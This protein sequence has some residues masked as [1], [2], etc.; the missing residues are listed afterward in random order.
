[1]VAVMYAG[2]VVEEGSVAEVFGRASHPY[3]QGLLD[4]VPIPGKLAPGAHLGYIP[5]QV[6]SLLG[7]LKGCA[8]RGRCSHA[9]PACEQTIPMAQGTQAGHRYRCLLA[10]AGHA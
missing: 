5:G 10:E 8:F 6:P 2:E 1:R 3:T 9:M 4:C 7:G